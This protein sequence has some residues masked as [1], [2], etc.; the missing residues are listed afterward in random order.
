MSNAKVMFLDVWVTVE[1]YVVS[2]GPSD[3]RFF[4]E[5]FAFV[6]EFGIVH[7]TC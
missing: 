7:L 4:G 2:L 1:G 3:A 6:V 5:T